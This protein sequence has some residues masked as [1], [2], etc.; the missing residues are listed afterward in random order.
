M[1]VKEVRV[2]N[3]MKGLSYSVKNGVKINHVEIK[4]SECKESFFV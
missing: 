2:S 3:L 4:C 1:M